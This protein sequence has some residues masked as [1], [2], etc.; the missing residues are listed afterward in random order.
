MICTA[1]VCAIE[2]TTQSPS[3]HRRFLA[4]RWFGCTLG[5]PWGPNA[6]FALKFAVDCCGGVKFS[7]LLHPVKYTLISCP[8]FQDHL[9]ISELLHLPMRRSRQETETRT[10]LSSL[11][12]CTMTS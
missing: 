1:L 8:I 11:G 10:S 7:S 4:L 2:K 5:R 12:I 6:N 3:N 9:T